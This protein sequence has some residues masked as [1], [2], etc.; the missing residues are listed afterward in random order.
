M[1]KDIQTPIK[2]LNKSPSK[3]S[4]KIENKTAKDTPSG[5]YKRAKR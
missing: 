4:S 2:T 3:G 1:T 5:N